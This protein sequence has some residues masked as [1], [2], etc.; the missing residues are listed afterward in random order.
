MKVKNDFFGNVAGSNCFGTKKCTVVTKSI[1]ILKISV[2]IKSFETGL[3]RAPSQIKLFAES[4]IHY[5][6]SRHTH[7]LNALNS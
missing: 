6:L 4:H 3:M 1:S 7:S 5:I 2:N